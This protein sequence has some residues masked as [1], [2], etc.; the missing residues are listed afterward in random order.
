MRFHTNGK[1]RQELK[2]V[3]ENKLQTRTMLTTRTENKEYYNTEISVKS[4]LIWNNHVHNSLM[5]DFRWSISKFL[6]TKFINEHL[7]L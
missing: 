5:L 6:M 3:I 2:D 7:P 4:H 1:R